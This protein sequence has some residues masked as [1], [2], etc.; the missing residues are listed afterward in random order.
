LPSLGSRPYTSISEHDIIAILK[1]IWKGPAEKPG[2]A[3]R[4]IAER[5]LNMASARASA[6]S[7]AERRAQN[8]DPLPST[9]VNPAEWKRLAD[10]GELATKRAD[11]QLNHAS[12]PWE[13]VP[14]LM[15]RLY[16]DCQDHRSRALTLVILTGGRLTEIAEATWGEIDLK[17]KLWTLPAHRIKNK[18]DDHTC[19]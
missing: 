4:S 11:K 10:L 13:I 8:L 19:R 2:S 1:P 15:C 3:L 7:A 6:K 16:A 18:E 14:E 12:L 17:K 5:V 9:Y